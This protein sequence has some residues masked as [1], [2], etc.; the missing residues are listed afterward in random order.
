MNGC[1]CCVF[2]INSLLIGQMILQPDEL[3]EQACEESN[4]LSG[5]D[6][7]NLHNEEKLH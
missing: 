2:V 4:R 7:S 5:K 1:S 6:Q 3:W